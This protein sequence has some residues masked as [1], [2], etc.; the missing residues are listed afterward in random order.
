MCHPTQWLFLFYILAIWP[1]LLTCQDRPKK[2]NCADGSSNKTMCPERVKKQNCADGERTRICVPADYIKFELPEDERP[3][4]VKV[5]VDIKDIPKVNDKDFSITMNAYFIVKWQDR[6]LIVEKRN[7]TSKHFIPD[8]RIPDQP[9]PQTST[10][11]T[12]SLLMDS[13]TTPTSSN[14]ALHEEGSNRLTAVNLQIL[15]SLWLPDVEILNLKAFETHRVLSKLEGVWLDEEHHL[16]YALATRITFICPM[17]FNAFPM[18]IQRCKFQVGSFN[19]DMTKMV[20]ENEFVPNEEQAIK[21]ILDYQITI[22]NLKPEDTHYIAL[23]MNYSVA[24]FEMILQRKMSF[25]IVT[26]YL[27]SGLFVVVSW[28]SFLVNPEVIPGRMTLLVTIFLVLI[29]IF[30]TIQ[31]NSPKAEG[32]TAIEAWVIACIIFVFGALGEYTVILLKLKLTKLYPKPRQRRARRNGRTP[33]GPPAGMSA[34]TALTTSAAAVPLTM[35]TTA[36]TTTSAA[37]AASEIIS[38]TM[39]QFNALNSNHALGHL[40]SRKDYYARTDLTFLVVFPLLFLAFN[41]CYW[42][43]LLFWRRDEE[44]VHLD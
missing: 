22:Q 17:K 33:M 24:G 13:S 15:R 37:S 11:T 20:F 40:S 25:Y 34:T 38:P 9:Q 32:L 12:S 7:R 3:T 16:I 5:G 35:M 8:R 21:S 6:R 39:S 2:P 42:I 4:Y 36:T 29:N 19:Y 28:I 43:S 1:S 31:T 23:T 18:D 14:I 30:N 26:Y 27:P 10:T 44:E 41:L